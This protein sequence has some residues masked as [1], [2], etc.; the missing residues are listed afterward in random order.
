MF[1]D[2]QDS[3]KIY[4]F[5]S[6]VKQ[7]E[8]KENPDIII[9]GVPGGVMPYDADHPNGF[10]IVNYLVSNALNV[11]YALLSLSYNEYDE[12]FWNFVI[13]YMKFR[14]EYPVQSFHLTNIFHDIYGDERNDRERLIYINQKKVEEKI[15]TFARKD[16]FSLNNEEIFISKIDE[17]ID[18]LS[19]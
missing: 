9:I 14:Y 5:N 15:K 10:G 11:D 16:I 2:I 19:N 8:D 7:I 4:L 13:N 6:Y 1:D 17:I 18:Y 3:E 12:S